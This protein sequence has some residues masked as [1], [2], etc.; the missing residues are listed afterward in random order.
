MILT[1]YYRF[2]RKAKISKSRLD[3]VLSTMSY[4]KFEQQRCTK[5]QRATEKRDAVSDGDLL[6][7]FLDVPKQ[8]GG[9]IHQQ[10]EKS[11]TIKG[12][13]LSSV[14]VPYPGCNVA[15]G[16]VAGTSDALLFVFNNFELVNGVVQPGASVEV[17]VARGKSKDRQR[18]YFMLKRGEL[19]GE[20]AALRAA[21]RPQARAMVQGV[22]PLY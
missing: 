13:N 2:E 19:D 12:K 4:G 6:V 5:S 22:L 10:A 15:F 17:Y 1:D 11:F 14:F 9:K 18:L 8:F 20:V 21:S 16:D 3:C 7:Y